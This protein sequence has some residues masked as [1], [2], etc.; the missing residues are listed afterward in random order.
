MLQRSLQSRVWVLNNDGYRGY[1]HVGACI[2]GVQGLA[3]LQA[4][5]ASIVISK[6][7]CC[8]TEGNKGM[9]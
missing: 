9:L 2:N 8:F 4:Q 5:H 3:I 7:K 1:S 6:Q